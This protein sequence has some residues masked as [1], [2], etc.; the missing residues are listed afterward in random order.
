M[1]KAGLLILLFLLTGCEVMAEHWRQLS[2]TMKIVNSNSSQK[3]EQ[4]SEQPQSNLDPNN[5]KLI[6]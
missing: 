2:T 4:C 6:T 1:E 5:I 3:I